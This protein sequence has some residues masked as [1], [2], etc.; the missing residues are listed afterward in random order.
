MKK[1]QEYVGTVE[2]TEF[3]N[4]GL[5]NYTEEDGRVTKVLVKGVVKG[6]KVKFVLN[7]KRSGK[8]EGRV[9][10]VVMQSP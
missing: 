2:K 6:Q 7:K 9:L 10:E 1:G 8:C 5:I 4:K 3:P